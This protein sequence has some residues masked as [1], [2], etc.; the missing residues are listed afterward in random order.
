MFYIHLLGVKLSEDDLKKI[1]T[2]RNISE[3]YVKVCVLMPVT[4]LVF[5]IRSFVIA[6]RNN[7]RTAATILFMCVMLQP[8]QATTK[9]I[10]NSATLN[11]TYNQ[12]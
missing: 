6:V 1:E 2:C 12:L 9:N 4:L 10:C 8:N 5:I 7:I 3:M 11:Q